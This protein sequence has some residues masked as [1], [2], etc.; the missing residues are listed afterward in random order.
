MLP[1]LAISA[2][3]GFPA[4]YLTSNDNH[5][6]LYSWMLV[7]SMQKCWGRQRGPQVGSVFIGLRSPTNTLPDQDHPSCPITLNY[8]Y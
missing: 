1:A 5:Y 7:V 8:D 4:S 6:D 2:L 3:C